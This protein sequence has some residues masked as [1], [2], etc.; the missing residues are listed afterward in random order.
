MCSSLNAMESD[1]NMSSVFN[2]S[3]RDRVVNISQ[4]E[5]REFN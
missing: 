4:I 3:Y 1:P 2:E 5:S